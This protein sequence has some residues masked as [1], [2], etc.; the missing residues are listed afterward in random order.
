MFTV[1]VPFSPSRSAVFRITLDVSEDTALRADL[2]AVADR[3]GNPLPDNEPT[4]QLRRHAGMSAIIHAH[5]ALLTA[6][7]EA[8]AAMPEA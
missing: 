6:G 5:I 1:H 7:C 2:I 3:S 8:N 4:A